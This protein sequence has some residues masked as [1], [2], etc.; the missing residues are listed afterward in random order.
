MTEE[1]TES[2][3]V[4][5]I[6]GGAAGLSAAVTLSRA[7]RKIVLIDAGA[8]RN[9]PAAGVHGFL[10]RDGI[11][12][13]ELVAA[14]S[15]EVVG[16]GGLILAGEATAARPT[17]AGFAVS[18][19]DGRSVRARRLLV[20]TGLVDELPD[21]PGVRSRWGRDVL[22]CPYCHGWEVRDQ[23]I[24]VLG[25][26]ERAVHQALLFRQWTSDVVLFL[27]TAPVPTAAE[28][29]QLAARG[30]QVL[31]GTV[32]SLEIAGDRL[33][34][35]RLDGGAVVPRQAV[36]VMPRFAARSELLVSLGL[37]TTPHPM[38]VGDYIAAGPTGLTDIPGVY[39]AG[40]VTDLMAQVVGAAAGGVMAAAAINLD[41][42]AEDTELAVL[43]YRNTARELATGN[44][45]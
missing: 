32:A 31:P 38:G 24:G 40:N 42:I 30:V 36:T 11:S 37:T 10:T 1:T 39:V 23:A 18:L 5:I 9:S 45:R 27:H 44:V 7:R 29:E 43:D 6:G 21:I 33:V 41:L 14:G 26:T 22:H 2:F 17:E 25:T 4:A 19:A 35:V 20:T 12:P 8:P 16:F 3:D 15:R 13:A 28:S 34:G